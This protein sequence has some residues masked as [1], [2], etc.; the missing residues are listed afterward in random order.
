MLVESVAMQVACRL[1]S[2]R[3]IAHCNHPLDRR[4]SS[5][6]LWIEKGRLA[7]GVLGS[8]SYGPALILHILHGC[9]WKHAGRESPYYKCLQTVDGKCLAMIVVH[10]KGYSKGWCLALD[11]D[12]A[13][14]MLGIRPILLPAIHQPT[15]WLRYNCK[16]NPS[17]NFQKWC[18]KGRLKLVDFTLIER[19]ENF[20]FS[21][22]KI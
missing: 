22:R 16:L 4:W 19:T 11:L 21:R 1:H 6:S 14:G 5:L 13:S 8:G 18:L 20:Q 12:S 10:D 9:N 2:N 7:V 15:A 17:L 3:C